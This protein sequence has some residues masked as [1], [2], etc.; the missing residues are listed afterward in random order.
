MMK[1]EVS[2]IHVPIQEEVDKHIRKKVIEL[3]FMEREHLKTCMSP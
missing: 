3:V 1:I 2:G